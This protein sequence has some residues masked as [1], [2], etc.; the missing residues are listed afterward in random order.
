M[1]ENIGLKKIWRE[2]KRPFKQLAGLLL[3]LCP[4][5]TRKKLKYHLEF[6]EWVKITW[7]KVK[8]RSGENP[9]FTSDKNRLRLKLSVLCH[10]LYFKCG[11]CGKYAKARNIIEDDHVSL[12]CPFCGA[13]EK[14]RKNDFRDE[15]FAA[16]ERSVY[17]IEKSIKRRETGFIRALLLAR[18]LYSFM[19]EWR[20]E[21]NFVLASL[22]TEA[23]GHEVVCSS[24]ILIEEKENNSI[25]L[26]C[27]HMETLNKKFCANFT[28][29]DVW[30]QK[31]LISPFLFIPFVYATFRWKSVV[32][33]SN[34]YSYFYHIPPISDF[35]SIFPKWNDGD[36]KLANLELQRMNVDIKTPY[37]CFL[38]R[39]SAYTSSLHVNQ[40]F[41]IPYNNRRNMPVS[42]YYESMKWLNQKGYSVFRM[43]FMMKQRVTLTNDKIIDYAHFY[44]T[45]FMDLYLSSTCRIFISCATGL[46]ALPLICG[47][48]LLF[49]NT[50]YIV[51]LNENLNYSN[52]YLLPRKIYDTKDE[53]FVSLAE[54][55]C[56]SIATE[57]YPEN[58]MRIDSRPGEI[59]Q[60]VMETE[61]RLSGVWKDTEQDME[62][63]ERYRSIMRFYEGYPTDYKVRYRVG[64]DFL[65]ENADWFLKQNTMSHLAAF[66]EHRELE[67]N[68][69]TGELSIATYGMTEENIKFLPEGMLNVG[70]VI[71]NFDDNSEKWG[72][73]SVL[74]LKVLPPQ[75]IKECREKFDAILIMSDH[76]YSISE[77]LEE[78]GIEKY[79]IRYGFESNTD[80]GRYK[81]ILPK[82]FRVLMDDDIV[83]KPGN[84]PKY[85]GNEWEHSRC[86]INSPF[87]SINNE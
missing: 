20:G 47:V 25:I 64:A 44:R 84:R 82:E 65:R 49:V 77:K 69:W 43:G 42:F 60:I 85:T 39:D 81:P 6:I 10:T 9:I 13:H 31:M 8:N 78:T 51:F 36:T 33:Y 19:R 73:R 30:K 15:L 71:A 45:E 86:M 57:M 32:R 87:Y 80:K 72:K 1:S 48:P 76:Y 21:V 63:Q 53:R 24:V 66:N 16:L 3:L 4:K 40:S 29:L 67:K 54:M 12:N 17:P 27:T 83:Y 75:K 28:L 74:G 14:M 58:I 38:N 68:I 61:N 22:L 52:V 70:N 34:D 23:I 11:K 7:R 5:K 2:I 35:K 55:Y 41:T 50:Y 18:S 59:L 46:D 79:Y 37:I 56:R 62:L 26:A